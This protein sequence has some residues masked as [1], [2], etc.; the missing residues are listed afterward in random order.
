[1][2]ASFYFLDI[3][4]FPRTFPALISFLPSKYFALP[5][6]AQRAPTWYN[7]KKSECGMR[8]IRD[9]RAGSAN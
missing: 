1:M 8:R 6:V 9:T 2:Q 7:P 3:I 4:I 5:A